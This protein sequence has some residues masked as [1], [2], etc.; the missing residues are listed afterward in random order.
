MGDLAITRRISLVAGLLLQSFPEFPV[1]TF[2]LRGLIFHFFKE[3]DIL[4]GNTDLIAHGVNQPDF[5]G[6]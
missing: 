5:F 1:G 6:R 2:Q 3:I 4:D